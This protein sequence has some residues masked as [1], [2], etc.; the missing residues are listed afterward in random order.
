MIVRYMGLKFSF[1]SIFLSLCISVSSIICCLESR[2]P[3]YVHNST[4]SSVFNIESP[5][6]IFAGFSANSFSP[7]VY[8]PDFLAQTQ[9]FFKFWLFKKLVSETS[10]S[11]RFF[12]VKKINFVVVSIHAP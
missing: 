11:L 1:L 4:E 6:L 12:A 10:C 7:V 9:A 2:T 3:I 5:A 8:F